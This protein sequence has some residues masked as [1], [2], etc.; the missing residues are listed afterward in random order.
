MANVES[1]YAMGVIVIFLFLYA[2]E[3][4]YMFNRNTLV[5][6]AGFLLLYYLQILYK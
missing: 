4:P 1:I 5:I 6:L 3:M 2:I